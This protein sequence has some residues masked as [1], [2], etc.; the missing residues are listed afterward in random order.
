MNGGIHDGWCLSESLKDIFLGG[1]PLTRLGLYGDQRQK[2]AENEILKNAD[3]NRSRM[4]ERDKNHREAELVRLKKIASN[5][6]RAREFL[7]KSSMI[8]GLKEAEGYTH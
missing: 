3:K 5:P 1:L 6:K 7:M 4:Q 2:I 8:K